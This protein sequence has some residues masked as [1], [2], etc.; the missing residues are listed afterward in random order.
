MLDDRDTPTSRDNRAPVWN[1]R[2]THAAWRAYLGDLRD[3]PPVY[4]APARQTD[5]AGLPPAY[6]FVGDGEPFCHETLAYVD[7]LNRAGVPARA[8][9]YPVR[10][11]AFDM[12]TPWRAVSRRAVA[13]FEA[14]YRD[15]AAKYRSEQ[16]MD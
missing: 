15:A 9:V 14:A 12:L 10:V 6:T 11:H 5:Y 2:R 13:A 4:A 7:A 1:T 8:D 16:T 3:A